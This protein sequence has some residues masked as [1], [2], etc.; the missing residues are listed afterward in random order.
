GLTAALALLALPL[1]RRGVVRLA[2]ALALLF[3]LTAL[4]GPVH[5][6]LYDWVALFDQTRNAERAWSGVNFFL[7]LLGGLGIA[8][9]LARF[10]ALRRESRGAWAGVALALALAPLL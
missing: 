10:D 8:A 1:W 5:R 9:L 4:G 3:A 2:F 6:F 7:P